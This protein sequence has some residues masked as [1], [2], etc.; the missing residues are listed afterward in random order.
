MEAIE[1]CDERGFEDGKSG[2]PKVIVVSYVDR[3][4]LKRGRLTLASQASV[5]NAWRLVELM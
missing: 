3:E 1:G 2:G 4:G 5:V